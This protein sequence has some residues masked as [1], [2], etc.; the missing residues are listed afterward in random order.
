MLSIK[1]TGALKHCGIRDPGL[2]V[3]DVFLPLVVFGFFYKQ[4]SVHKYPISLA[5]PHTPWEV[6]RKA[7]FF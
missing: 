3:E 2:L 4:D 7:S 6:Y 5:R 1:S